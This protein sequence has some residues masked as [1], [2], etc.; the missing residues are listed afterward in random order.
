MQAI[1]RRGPEASARAVHR[2]GGGDLRSLT[3]PSRRRGRSPSPAP[4]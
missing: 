4:A 1:L 3:R 2:L